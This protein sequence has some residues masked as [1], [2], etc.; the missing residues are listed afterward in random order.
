MLTCEFFFL[1]MKTIY[2]YYS[3]YKLNFHSKYLWWNRQTTVR[4]PS[5]KKNF[6]KN[7]S[8][9][10][11]I[12]KWL[13]VAKLIDLQFQTQMEK[14]IFRTEILSKTGALIKPTKNRVTI[15]SSLWTG[16]LIGTRYLGFHWHDP[17]LPL[18][19]SLWT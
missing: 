10:K 7:L 8:M 1:V 2:T 15:P 16:Y 5:L 13:F 12:I 11:V 9:W 18:L 3:K 19:P 14:S 17:H 4:F 6:N